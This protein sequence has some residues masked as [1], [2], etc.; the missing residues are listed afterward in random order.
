MTRWP[1]LGPRKSSYL[2]CADTNQESNLRAQCARWIKIREDTE[3]VVFLPQE[4]QLQKLGSEGPML[5]VE[6]QHAGNHV[7]D[8][9]AITADKKREYGSAT[10]QMLRFM[11]LTKVAK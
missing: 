5:R 7:P 4:W 2:L 9:G 8:V 3:F 10:T 6:C 11:S 1:F